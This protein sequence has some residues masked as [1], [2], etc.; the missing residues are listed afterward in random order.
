V[1]ITLL[2][3]AARLSDRELL[4]RVTVLAVRERQANLELV[5]H[6]AELDKRRLY[7]GEGYG[8]LFTYCTEALHLA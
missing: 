1:P 2:A 4:R 5:A 3:A 8:S 7:R 6:L